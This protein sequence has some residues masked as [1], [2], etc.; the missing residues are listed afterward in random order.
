M[1]VFSFTGT[2]QVKMTTFNLSFLGDLSLTSATAE[3]LHW[4]SG[5]RASIHIT[6]TDLE[7]VVAGDDL[8]ELTG[9]TITG[10]HS[11]IRNGGE[12][13]HVDI[14]QLNIDAELFYDLIQAR[15]G[16]GLLALITSGNDEMHGT[17]GNDILNGGAGRDALLGMTG[18]DKLL[19][20]DGGDRLDGGGGNDTLTGGKGADQF[21]FTAPPGGSLDTITDFNVAQDSFQIWRQFFPHIGPRGDL[22]DGRF[23]LGTQATTEEQ[24]VPYDA[25]TG[26]LW[27]DRDGSGGHAAVQF[28][29]L[30]A[31]LAITGGMFDL[32]N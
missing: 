16:K 25:A 1:A 21:I 20:G 27:F 30:A 23:G 19:G 9:G 4:M 22:T 7:P 32:V 8:A 28:A 6:G 15:D 10:F 14:Y 5:G 11:D 17:E 31:G 13:E 3:E 29:Q 24:R 26:A 2:P 12:H 18:D